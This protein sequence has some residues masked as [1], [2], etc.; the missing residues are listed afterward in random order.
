MKN[1]IIFLFVVLTFTGFSVKEINDI[2]AQWRLGEAYLKDTLSGSF[3]TG[4]LWL[5]DS[6]TTNNLNVRGNMTMAD[7]SYLQWDAADALYISGQ[8][9]ELL[10]YANTHTFNTQYGNRIAALD[11]AT[12]LYVDNGNIV[13]DNFTQLG[14]SSPLIKAKLL[15]HTTKVTAVNNYYHV[16]HGISD[17]EKIISFNL[18][19]LRDTTAE[20]M[21]ILPVSYNFST[22][23]AVGSVYFVNDS[24]VTWLCPANSTALVG[25][26]IRVML[27]YIQ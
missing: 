14:S 24:A 7:A 4:R 5:R 2:A 11:S 9:N 21:A 27:F 17:I 6:L 1:I 10:F 25:D 26:S 3:V 8:I 18:Y 15:R 19:I 23:L 20:T 12:G 16:L 22:P 13:N